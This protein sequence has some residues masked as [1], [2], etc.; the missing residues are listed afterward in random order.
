MVNYRA[1]FLDADGTLFDYD[2][3]EK[4]ALEMSLQDFSIKGDQEDLLEIYREINKNIWAEFEKGEISAER[5][6]TER[7]HRFGEKLGVDLNPKIFSEKYLGYLGQASFLLEG[8]KEVL[9]WLKGDYV[10]ILLTNGLSRVQRS[11]VKL[12]SLEDYFQELVISEEIGE[13]KPAPGIFDRAMEA[14]GNPR[15][16]EVLMVGD[17]LESDIKGGIGYGL[18]TCWIRNGGQNTNPGVTP[19]FIIDEIKE[20]PGLLKGGKIDG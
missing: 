3:G 18:D 10:L 4:F 5:L 20:L 13:A 14:A 6:K 2:R 11:R 7:F 19:T 12:A 1:I 17:S 15:R 16:E 9:D 8:A